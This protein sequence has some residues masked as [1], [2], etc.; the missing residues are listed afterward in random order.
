MSDSRCPI[1]VLGLGNLL[2]SDD[3]FGLE[4]LTRL[5]DSYGAKPGVE[6]LDGG[7]LGTALLGEIEGRQALLILDA[8]GGG[9]PGQVSCVEDPL[10]Y[11]SPQGIGGHGANA[12]GLLAAASLLNWLPEHVAVVGATPLSLATNIG[13]SD[14]L[15]KALPEAVGL[16]EATLAE[17]MS[18]IDGGALCTS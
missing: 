7:T 1:L 2:L 9:T 14:P 16:A 15:R 12:S 4:L 13:L 10:R 6:F 3:G 18:R 11:P 17:F 5:R 8:V